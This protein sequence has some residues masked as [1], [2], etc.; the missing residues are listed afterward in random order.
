MPKTGKENYLS[1]SILSA[2]LVDFF[3][4]SSLILF[5]LAWSELLYLIL[6]DFVWFLAAGVFNPLGGLRTLTGF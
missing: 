2:T 3:S 5:L 6:L 4:E 1:F